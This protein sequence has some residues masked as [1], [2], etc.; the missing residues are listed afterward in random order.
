MSDK[1]ALLWVRSLASLWGATLFYTVAPAI[2]PSWGNPE[3]AT[4][5]LPEYI[6]GMGWLAVGI[7]LLY[8][9]ILSWRMAYL[10]GAKK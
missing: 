7:T 1:E 2:L 8:L 10:K 4:S 5:M 6:V 9:L 3:F